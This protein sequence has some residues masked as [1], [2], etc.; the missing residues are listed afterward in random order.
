MFPKRTFDLLS[1][2]GFKMYPPKSYTFGKGPKFCQRRVIA[3]PVLPGGG[4]EIP[5]APQAR[6]QR[7]DGG[8]WQKA[9]PGS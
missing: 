6:L 8:S 4:D 3:S 2:V 5:Q 1:F 9:M 7:G